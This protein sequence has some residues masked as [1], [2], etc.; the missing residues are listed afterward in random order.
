MHSLVTRLQG[1]YAHCAYCKVTP[2][3]FS[4]CCWAN[5]AQLQTTTTKA[6]EWQ[7]QNQMGHHLRHVAS[8]HTHTYV[9]AM[10]VCVCLCVTYK[11]CNSLSANQTC[12]QPSTILTLAAV[13]SPSLSFS[14]SLSLCLS[15]PLSFSSTSSL[16]WSPSLSV[17]LSAFK[18]CNFVA[19]YDQKCSRTT[20]KS[21]ENTCTSPELIDRVTN[22]P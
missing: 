17:C 22:R 20:W 15:L 10:H 8:T 18:C 2:L 13:L 5:K 3:N 7:A 21:I 16:R 4:T 6:A 19:R 1:I 12:P 9:F 14:L 11:L